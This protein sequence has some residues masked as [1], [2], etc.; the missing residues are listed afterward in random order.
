MLCQLNAG[1]NLGAIKFNSVLPW[2]LDADI[3]VHH[4]NLTAFDK[5]KSNFLAKNSG[6][7]WVCIIDLIYMCVHVYICIELFLVINYK[8]LYVCVR[9]CVCM[10]IYI[11][12]YL[13]DAKE[14][15]YFAFKFGNFRSLTKVM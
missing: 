9:A 13:Y 10:Y 12:T 7:T 3:S 4:S 5:L 8:T 1:T 2:E 15:N 6:F 14:N 11:L